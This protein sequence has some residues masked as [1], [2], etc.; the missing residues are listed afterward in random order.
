MTAGDAGVVQ[1]HHS[2]MWEAI[3]AGIDL[4]FTNRSEA[5]ALVACEPSAAQRAQRAQLQ[6]G[7]LSAEAAALRLG[8]HCSLVCVTDG[9]RGSVLTA[10][11]QLHTVPPCWAKDKPVD[12]CGAGSWRVQL[13]PC[14]GVGAARQA[15]WQ[16]AG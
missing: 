1:R 6:H 2:E 14:P 12:T 16:A 11:G 13:C 4:L 8:P 10:L 5:E 15:R 9:S 3:D 7:E